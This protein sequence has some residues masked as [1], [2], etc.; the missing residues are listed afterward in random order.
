LEEEK[1]FFE[2]QLLEEEEKNF[3]EEQLL[4]EEKILQN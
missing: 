4:E 2:K 1:V 3:F